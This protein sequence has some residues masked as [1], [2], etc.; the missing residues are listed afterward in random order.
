LSEFLIALEGR[1]DN[2]KPQ[3]YSN[4][5]SLIGSL[6]TKTAKLRERLVDFLK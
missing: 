4:Y 1:L 3:T 2:L 6:I 5:A